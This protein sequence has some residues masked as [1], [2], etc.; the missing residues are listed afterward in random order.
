M[1]PGERAFALQV[2]HDT[3]R[4][5]SFDA[6]RHRHVHSKSSLRAIRPGRVSQSAQTEQQHRRVREMHV[7]PSLLQVPRFARCVLAHKQLR[8]LSSREAAVVHLSVKELIRATA[9]VASLKHLLTPQ[10]GAIT[11]QQ[12]V[13]AITHLAHVHDST[14]GPDSD[15]LEALLRTLDAE[16]CLGLHGSDLASVFCSVSTWQAPLCPCLLAPIASELL[17]ETQFLPKLYTI[18]SSELAVL[19]TSLARQPATASSTLWPQLV[20]ALA[21][22]ASQLQLP[23]LVDV[24]SLVV[25]NEKHTETFLDAVAAAVVAQQELPTPEQVCWSLHSGLA[26]SYSTIPNVLPLSTAGGSHFNKSR[27]KLRAVM[28]A[29]PCWLCTSMP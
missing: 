21:V 16:A 1:H 26:S 4:L 27:P 9:D 23:Q 6:M 15:L 10:W 29:C 20:K 17:R 8:C 2:D 3:K 12:A 7:M 13:A 24:T 18:S 28:S 25:D 14:D 19:A 11:P 5:L 22:Q